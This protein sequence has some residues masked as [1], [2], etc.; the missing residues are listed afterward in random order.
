[1]M[2]LLMIT[3][4]QEFNKTNL[5]SRR[6]KH[7]WEEEYYVEFRLL[8]TTNNIPIE[9]SSSNL[10]KIQCFYL[11]YSRSIIMKMD[12]TS[13]KDP[14]IYCPKNDSVVSFDPSSTEIYYTLFKTLSD[15]STNEYHNINSNHKA[16]VYM[17]FLSCTLMD[18]GTLY[19]SSKSFSIKTPDKNMQC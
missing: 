7:D 3:L 16:S 9:A 14:L 8:N 19:I 15:S 13:Y 12:D 5:K 6:H 2:F 10:S 17:D 18:L 11:D 1:M 4:F